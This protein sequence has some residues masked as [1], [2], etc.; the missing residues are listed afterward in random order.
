MTSGM[1]TDVTAEAPQVDENTRLTAAHA[2][3][4]R[5]EDVDVPIKQFKQLRPF[6]KARTKKIAAVTRIQSATKI[7]RASNV[8]VEIMPGPYA[9]DR[10]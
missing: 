4:G 9:W 2:D 5:S 8:Q 6:Q 1:S 3:M 7:P 10:I